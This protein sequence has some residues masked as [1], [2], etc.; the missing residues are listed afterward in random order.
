MKAS[1]IRAHNVAN[2]R[3]TAS[4]LAGV[5]HLP[6][7]RPGHLED[8]E[9]IDNTQDMRLVLDVSNPGTDVIR[10]IEHYFGD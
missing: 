7:V 5:Y 10:V 6:F 4:E 2:Y 3:M 8:I 9:S 1:K